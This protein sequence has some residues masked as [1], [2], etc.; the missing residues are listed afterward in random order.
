MRSF[1]IKGNNKVGYKTF[2]NNKKDTVMS[3][4]NYKQQNK[5]IKIKDPL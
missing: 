3:F 5:P 2:L 1:R 4:I